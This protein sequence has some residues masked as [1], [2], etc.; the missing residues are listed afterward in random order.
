VAYLFRGLD[1]KLMQTVIAAGFMFLTYEE[2]AALIFK[3]FG[4]KA[5]KPV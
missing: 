5:K 4:L 1:A 3:L 2:M